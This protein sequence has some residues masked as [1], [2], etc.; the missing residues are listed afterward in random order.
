[1]YR[2]TVLVVP[3][4]SLATVIMSCE[5]EPNLSCA[6]TYSASSCPC[7]CARFI[8]IRRTYQVLP[9]NFNKTGVGSVLRDQRNCNSA[10]A[11]SHRRVGIQAGKPAARSYLSRP[12]SLCLT[13]ESQTPFPRDVRSDSQ[14]EHSIFRRDL[15]AAAVTCSQSVLSIALNLGLVS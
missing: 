15:D 12:P 3:T 13:S 6:G 9:R 11:S 8:L 2:C 4:Q 1:M 7:T 5:S 14:L 10:R